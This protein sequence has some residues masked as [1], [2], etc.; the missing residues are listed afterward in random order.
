MYG[1]NMKNR[2]DFVR[3]AISVSIMFTSRLSLVPL[4]YLGCSST[5][6]ANT[7]PPEVTVVLSVVNT[8]NSILGKTSGSSAQFSVLNLKLDQI[9]KNQEE[10][11]DGLRQINLS[12]DNL[13]RAIPDM[14]EDDDYNDIF[15]DVDG[16]VIDFN[17]MLTR[18]NN[19]EQKINNHDE[20]VNKLN[21][22]STRVLSLMRNSNLYQDGLSSIL[23]GCEMIRLLCNIT[24]LAINFELNLS[25]TNRWKNQREHTFREIID[26]LNQTNELFISN[27]IKQ[28]HKYE[29]DRYSDLRLQI[30]KLDWSGVYF[31][32]IER[33]NV[34][35]LDLSLYWMT[36]ANFKGVSA[37]THMYIVN[38]GYKGKEVIEDIFMND[39]LVRFKTIYGNDNYRY[40]GF[41]HISDFDRDNVLLTQAV[42]SPTNIP[43]KAELLTNQVTNKWVINYPNPRTPASHLSGLREAY[44]S[45]T[46][47]RNIAL[48]QKPQLI[49]RCNR[50]GYRTTNIEAI[51]KIYEICQELAQGLLTIKKSLEVNLFNDK[52]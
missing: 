34:T 4:C 1:V 9:I 24:H 18:E 5:A 20:L 36:E 2:R 37:N 44:R 15:R 23:R 27:Q 31:R 14:L 8:L 13:L 16:L 6:R 28:K 30:S 32:Q 11:I 19:I 39:V 41:G 49:D 38:I 25:R 21:N 35:D 45:S 12:I 40:V 46:D 3:S 7:F 33:A 22:L 47:P 52:W 17:N 50:I 43:K 51:G 42:Q 29:R 10:I 26:K 48:G